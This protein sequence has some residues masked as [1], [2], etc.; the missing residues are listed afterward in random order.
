MLTKLTLHTLIATA[1]LG[2]LAIAWQAAAPAGAAGLKA[3]RHAAVDN[4]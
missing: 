1:V 3:G 2:L 4:D